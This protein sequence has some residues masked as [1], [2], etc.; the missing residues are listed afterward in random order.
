MAYKY[1]PHRQHLFEMLE[2]LEHSGTVV[3]ELLG[4]TVDFDECYTES[5]LH[6]RGFAPQ[7]HLT[8]CDEQ[9]RAFTIMVV[10]HK[11]GLGIGLVPDGDPEI[12]DAEGFE[13]EPWRAA[14]CAEYARLVKHLLPK[15]ACQLE[16]KAEVFH[17]PAFPG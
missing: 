8:F 5:P 3:A 16:K 2:A 10:A 1:Q 11:G 17:L 12:G 7:T 15:E 9:G 14:V 13:P 4:L 6:D